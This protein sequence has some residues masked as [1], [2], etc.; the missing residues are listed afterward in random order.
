V[1]SDDAADV[2]TFFGHFAAFLGDF[3]FH[4]C[5]SGAYCWCGRR[6]SRRGRC[7]RCPSCTC[8]SWPHNRTARANP[9]ATSTPSSPHYVAKWVLWGMFLSCFSSGHPRFA[10]PFDAVPLLHKHFPR[11]IQN[12]I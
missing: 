3:H 7:G 8:C 5:V 6:P 1:V 10:L 2:H 9:S 4:V 11:A 12:M